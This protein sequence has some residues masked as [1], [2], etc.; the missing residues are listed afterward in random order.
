VE[1]QNLTFSPDR[2][3][4][5]AAVTLEDPSAV[6]RYDLVLQKRLGN[7]EVVS[8]WLGAETEKPGAIQPSK[9]SAEK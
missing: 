5:L 9:P 4:A 7:W 6:A 2:L 3:R 1:I 8:V